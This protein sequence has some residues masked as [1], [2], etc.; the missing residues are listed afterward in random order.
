[1]IPPQ[2]CPPPAYTWKPLSDSVIYQT[3]AKL[4]PYK[5]RQPGSIPNCVYKYNA[6]VLVPRLGPIFRA[7]D[8]L[9]YYPMDWNY[10]HFIV[11]RKPGQIDY[12][13]PASYWPIVLSKGHPG[14][15]NA[16]CT[17]QITMEAEKTGVL[18]ATQYRARPGR[19]MTNA[20]HMV[21]KTVMDAWRSKEVASAPINPTRH[22]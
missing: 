10:T 5:A 15:E 4:K 19:A 2:Q 21:V 18:P 17:M 8:D 9:N 1:M 12:T 20:I 14:L 7:G 3:I 11:L 6:H 22:L 16:A 13:S